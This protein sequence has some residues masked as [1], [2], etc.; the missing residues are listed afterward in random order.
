MRMESGS[1]SSMKQ[2]CI[3]GKYTHIERFGWKCALAMRTLINRP[4][5]RMRVSV[6]VP[7]NLNQNDNR[8][9]M[10]TIHF[11]RFL[12]R[13][14]LNAQKIFETTNTTTNTSN[15]FSFFRSFHWP[16]CFFF[17]LT[18]S[19]NCDRARPSHFFFS[20]ARYHQKHTSNSNQGLWI[21]INFLQFSTVSE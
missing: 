17:F 7:K 20:L 10:N 19:T 18:S 14:W 13:N 11:W 15:V 12:D 2:L 6:C 16:C 4:C 5:M 21:W 9:A 3:H 8:S 1:S